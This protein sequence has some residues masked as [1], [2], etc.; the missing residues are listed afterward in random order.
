M[1][2]N[3]QLLQTMAKTSVLVKTSKRESVAY[4]RAE[5][6]A[7]KHNF[8][9]ENFVKEAKV[10]FREFVARADKLH[11]SAR[12]A[13]AEK[14][15]VGESSDPCDVLYCQE[16]FTGHPELEK[17]FGTWD[18][19]WVLEQCT[20]YGWGLPETNV[21]FMG[22]EGATTPAH[23]D[24]QHNFLNQVRGHKLVVLFPPDD[25]TCMYPFPVTHPCDRCSLVDVRNADLEHFPRFKQARGHVAILGPGDVLYIPYG[26][27]HYCRTLTHLAAS[28]TFW[29]QTTGTGSKVA[30]IPEKM[31]PHEW[32]RAR[33]NIE[34]LL[35]DDVGPSNLDAEVVRILSLLEKKEADDPRINALRHMLGVLQVGEEDQITFLTETFSGRFG[36]DLNPFV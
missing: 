14:C 9:G 26:W 23:F 30:E 27:W 10:P 22:S 16:T 6:N 15:S 33:R 24:E 21:L 18:W 36:F 11:D 31:G 28:I 32:T 13:E 34:K 29:S 4:F 7:G 35:A 2:T 8:S 1:G 19:K 17:E 25:Y 5:R 20:R 12:K 3:D